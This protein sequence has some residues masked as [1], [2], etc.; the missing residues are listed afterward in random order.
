MIL[1]PSVLFVSAAPH[2]TSKWFYCTHHQTNTHQEFFLCLRLH[3]ACLDRQIHQTNTTMGWLR[4]VGSLW[5][6]VSFAKEPCK[7]DYILQNRPIISRNL[8]IEATPSNRYSSRIQFVSTAPQCMSW[9]S[10]RQKNS[11]DKNKNSLRIP[12][13]SVASYRTC[14]HTNTAYCIWS[15]IRSQF[16]I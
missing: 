12:F 9:F 6:Y 13:L 1:L 14:Y 16:P 11:P 10:G 15:V 8:L 4:F 3:I 7:R 5:S 2:C